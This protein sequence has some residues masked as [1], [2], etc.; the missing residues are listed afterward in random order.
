MDNTLITQD[1]LDTFKRNAHLIPD[2]IIAEIGVYKGGSLKYLTELFP[3]REVIGFDTFEGLPKKFWLKSEHHEVGEFND[4]SFESVS[5][6]VPEAKLIKGLF[7]DSAEEITGKY[8]LVHI[9]TDY[10]KSI[11]ACLDYVWPKMAKGGMIVVDDYDWPNC[12]GVKKALEE[13][14]KPYVVS[15][16]YQAVIVK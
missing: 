4:T 13:L 10:Y 14:G 8:A 16:D 2:G 1:R 3:D 7:P 15:A 5:D 11:K 6:F 12:P 9:D